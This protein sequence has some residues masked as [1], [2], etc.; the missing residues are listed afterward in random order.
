MHCAEAQYASALC[1]A[2]PILQDGNY[3]AA[4][5]YL[6][7]PLTSNSPSSP[8][9]G[10]PP[11]S[12]RHFPGATTT[13]LRGSYNPSS[14]GGRVNSSVRDSP[15]RRD[16]RRNPAS[17]RTGRVTLATSSCTY[18]CATSLASRAPVLVTVADTLS[19]PPAPMLGAL[20]LRSLYSNDV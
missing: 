19:V 7:P 12:T 18:S 14:F 8:P 13:L 4:L 11:P 1:L 17:A 6:G 16:T 15:G 2:E 5:C 10:F 3:A 9:T 20:S